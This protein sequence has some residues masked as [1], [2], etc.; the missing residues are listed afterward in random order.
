MHRKASDGKVI[1]SCRKT[2]VYVFSLLFPPIHSVKWEIVGTGIPE[3]YNEGATHDDRRR[4][5][6]NAGH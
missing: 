3:T 1:L 5:D 6:A 2:S 4:Y